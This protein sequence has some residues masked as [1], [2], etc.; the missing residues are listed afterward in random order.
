M[1]SISSPPCLPLPRTADVLSQPSE[2]INGSDDDAASS[3]NVT[4]V[5][6]SPGAFKAFYTDASQFTHVRKISYLLMMATGLENQRLLE[7]YN[8]KMAD[9]TADF[10]FEP[11]P[12]MITPEKFVKATG[13]FN[14]LVS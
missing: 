13:P 11:C 8:N 9:G 1:P 12:E 14:I 6:L 5:A 10:E 4:P 7:E 2:S 3:V